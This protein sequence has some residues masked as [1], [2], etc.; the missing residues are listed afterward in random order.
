MVPKIESDEENCCYSKS[1]V[2]IH[3]YLNA[4]GARLH[5]IKQLLLLLL[6]ARISQV[7]KSSKVACFS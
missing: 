1:I 7:N 3:S 2:W 5:A 4:M 6:L